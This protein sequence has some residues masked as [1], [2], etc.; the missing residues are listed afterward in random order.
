MTTRYAAA[1]D[2]KRILTTH[3]Q[4]NAH[5]PPPNINSYTDAY[6]HA[7]KYTYKNAYECKMHKKVLIAAFLHTCTEINLMCMILRKIHLWRGT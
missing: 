3:T 4:H 1:R 6:T 7:S 2:A 5:T